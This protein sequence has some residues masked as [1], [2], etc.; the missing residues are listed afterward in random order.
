M[1]QPTQPVTT[2][3]TKGIVIALIIMILG[4]VSYFLGLGD[5]KP[6]QYVGYVI[7]IVGIIWSVNSYGKQIDYNSTLGNYFGHGFKI[8][9]L[10]TI[11]VIILTGL[12]LYIF[13][14]MKEKALEAA[15]KS[16]VEKNLT[17]EQIAQGMDFTKR[18]FM[19]FVL[20]WILVSYLFCGAIASLIGAGVTK[21]N[22]V[23]FTDGR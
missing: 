2:P 14:D 17:Q 22:P 13:P 10:V 23:Q 11:F 4:L 21:K 19:V 5:N 15:R 6:M 1:E 18:F 12:F 8:T 9:A 3:L 16:M 7:L 20:A